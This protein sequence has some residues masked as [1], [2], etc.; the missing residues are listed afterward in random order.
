MIAQHIASVNQTIPL[1]LLIEYIG[2]VNIATLSLTNNVI[3][4][5]K[6]TIVGGGSLVY[7]IIAIIILLVLLLTPF[8]IL[9]TI[10][11]TWMKR[12]N[13]DVTPVL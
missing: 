12:G 1:I 8:V 3:I 7:L 4:I 11:Y 13:Q 10:L 5:L 6:K 9:K 2:V